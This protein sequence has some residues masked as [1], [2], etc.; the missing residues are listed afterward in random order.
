MSMHKA[1]RY[2]GLYKPAKE[3]IRKFEERYGEKYRKRY[4]GY[5][6]RRLGLLT[7]AILVKKR[8]SK[9]RARDEKEMLRR[10]LGILKTHNNEAIA[11]GGAGQKP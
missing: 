10:L 9:P 4:S 1:I 6:R 11:G 5:A 7:A 2:L 8:V 3:N